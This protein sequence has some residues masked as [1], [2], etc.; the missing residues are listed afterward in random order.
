VEFILFGEV[1][2]THENVSVDLGRRQ[3]RCLLGLLLIETGHTI[4]TQRLADL[5]WD[6]QP[7]AAGRRVVQTYLARLRAMLAPR[8]V[9]I[10]TGNGGY[11]VDVAPHCI[12][13][14]R[15]CQSV[16]DATEIRSAPHRAKALAE[17]LALWR[18]PILGETASDQLRARVTAGFEEL[19]SSAVENYA[20]SELDSGHPAQA[21]VA[22]TPVALARP[23]RERAIELLMRAYVAA[24]RRGEALSTYRHARTTIAEELGIEPGTQLQSLHNEILHGVPA[25]ISDETGTGPRELPPA[26]PVFV[27]RRAERQRLVEV[28][29]RFLPGSGRA[30]ILVLHGR[31]GVGK[32]ALAV[33]VAHEVASAY[34]EGQVYLDL[35]GTTPGITPR[36]AFE[37]L[38]HA[39]RSLG[40]PAAEIPIHEGEAAA[41]LRS[42]TGDRRILFVLDNARDAAVV[43]QLIPSGNGCAVIVTSRVNLATLDP[44]LDL[45]IGG[46]DHTS[47]VQLLARLGRR[48]DD[49]SGAYDRI[50]AGCESLPL[51]LRIAGARLATQVGLTVAELA[52]RLSD[53][54]SRLDELD[55][56]GL[57]VRSSI[58]VSLDALRESTDPADQLAAWLL[59][60]LVLVPVPSFTADHAA[61]VAGH[62]NPA[63]VASAL[64][65]LV[66]LQM[67]RRLPGE[68]WGMH[69]LVRLFAIETG[70]RDVD[71]VERDATVDRLLGWYRAVASRVHLVLLPG[72]HLFG[73]PFEPPPNVPPP[74]LDTAEDATAWLE[75]EVDNILTVAKSDRHLFALHATR[76]LNW[77]LGK[78]SAVTHEMALA[79]LAVEATQEHSTAL[80]RSDALRYR[81]QAYLHAERVADAEHDLTVALE[82]AEGEDDRFRTMGLL[83]D[84]ARIADLRGDRASALERLSQC[85]GVART[86]GWV[87]QEALTLLNMSTVHI[88]LHQ[89]D[90]AAQALH[91]SLA[92]RR[93]SGDNA[94]RAIVLPALGYVSI[95]LGR[96]DEALSLFDEAVEVCT[97]VGNTVD[98]W[99]ARF[100]RS[101][102]H[103]LHGAA[104]PAVRDAVAA[105][106]MCNNGRPYWS[107]ATLR[108]L[109]IA[110]A[111]AGHATASAELAR[112][113]DL[114]YA[115]HNGHREESVEAMLALVL[116]R[117]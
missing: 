47:A 6:S 12:D 93:R 10:E 51:A 62:D 66:E 104:V 59:P 70:E 46:L 34:P 82:L 31:G 109:S 103:L 17:A 106:R 95:E 30:R 68:R 5:L 16:A 117:P 44:D 83:S 86:E 19:R 81:G 3:E 32:S 116:G 42:L 25:K 94:G 110:T 54:R 65:T 60:R 33:Q 8:G 73:G 61:A 64:A 18:G 90:E 45:D 24:G 99:F 2:A 26:V 23:I 69:D 98:G 1:R 20:Q 41:R 57:A 28:L 91:T 13:L 115:S 112:R 36:T 52:D 107:A 43:R 4:T 75:A 37:A 71:P 92:I 72:R 89:W 102:V 63:S 38:R 114:A 113:A 53:Q 88:G 105:M 85:L 79:S 74:A 96:L 97:L 56:E 77:L 14:H 35:C 29:H 108:L 27:G 87:T 101:V 40:I 48:A 84:L 78:R 76:A 111:R 7:P 58:Q 39:L 49:H 22:L 67:L 11:R 21:I 50:V 15:F 80:Q 9:Q 55:A 100:G